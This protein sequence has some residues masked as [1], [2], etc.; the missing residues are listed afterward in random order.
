[1]NAKEVR[2]RCIEAISHSG[3]RDPK[4]IV[5]D[6]KSL[7]EW[8]NAVEEKEQE[9]ASPHRGRPKKTGADKGNAPA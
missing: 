1:M 6:A 8:V 2:M 9:D 4:R 3:V 5:A 7:E